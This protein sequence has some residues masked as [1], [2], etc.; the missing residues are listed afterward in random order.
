MRKSETLGERGELVRGKLQGSGTRV[1]WRRGMLSACPAWRPDPGPGPRP[2]S[3]ETPPRP[4]AALAPAPDLSARGPGAQRAAS[5]PARPVASESRP[6]LAAAG[7]ERM[8]EEVGPSPWQ[9]HPALSPTP[10]GPVPAAPFSLAN[11]ASRD[12]GRFPGGGRHREAKA[13]APERGAPPTPA[14]RVGTQLTLGVSPA[15][16]VSGRLHRATPRTAL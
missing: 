7:L 5:I 12:A 2:P 15:A 6:R 16:P 14:L 1:C 11:G 3:R 10:I 8:E 13:R 4:S 9:P